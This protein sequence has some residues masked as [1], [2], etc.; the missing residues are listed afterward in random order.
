MIL[1]ILCNLQVVDFWVS[2]LYENLQ[3]GISIG[4]IEFSLIS[5][6]NWTFVIDSIHWISSR[7]SFH[8]DVSSHCLQN[9]KVQM[10]TTTIKKMYLEVY[11][12]FEPSQIRVQ[13]NLFEIVILKILSL[14]SSGVSYTK[15]TRVYPKGVKGKQVLPNC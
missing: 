1:A 5:F 8:F 9:R 15:V 12:N 3:N 13:V 2:I 7:N 6:L 10:T 4:L 14:W 11:L